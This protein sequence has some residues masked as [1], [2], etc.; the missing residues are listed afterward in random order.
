M[1]TFTKVIIG[2]I[3]AIMVISA[4]YYRYSH[5]KSAPAPAANSITQNVVDNTTR[6]DNSSNSA[7]ATNTAESTQTKEEALA[8][9]TDEF[10]KRVTK[11]YF[12]TYVTPENSPVKPERFTGYH[13]GV[14]VEFTDTDQD[15]PVYAVADSKVVLSRTA[16]GYGGVFMIQFEFQGKTYTALYGH[17][18]PSTLPAVGTTY[19]KNQR[20]AVLGSGFTSETDQERHHLHF[21]IQPG[22]SQDIRGYVQNQSEL[23]GWI[24]PLTLYK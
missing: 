16:S 21:S 22:T 3:L 24:N 14:D 6:F 9:P 15:V 19:T 2:S 18:R 1:G 8:T 11:K 13:T 23:S 17:I 20:I 12:G 5:N 4:A 7:N 10:Q